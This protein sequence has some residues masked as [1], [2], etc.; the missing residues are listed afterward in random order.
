MKILV[1]LSFYLRP[2]YSTVFQSQSS[3]DSTYH[4]NEGLSDEVY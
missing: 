1:D 2:L 4:F 3:E